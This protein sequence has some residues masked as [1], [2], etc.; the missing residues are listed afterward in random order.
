[1]KAF[2]VFE[3]MF[4]EAA[5]WKLAEGWVTLDRAYRDVNQGINETLNTPPRMALAASGQAHRFRYFAPSTRD[6]R[7]ESPAVKKAY[8]EARSFLGLK[9][10]QMTDRWYAEAAKLI[11]EVPGGEDQYNVR[12]DW[13]MIAFQPGKMEVNGWI[14]KFLALFGQNQLAIGLARPAIAASA[15]SK[16][17]AKIA[18]AVAV[19]K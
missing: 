18:P 9:T 16:L 10:Q 3:G 17:P 1:K 6:F 14:F 12:M 4:P 7:V 13:N 15:A 8:E 5:R 19:K 11:S 2:Q